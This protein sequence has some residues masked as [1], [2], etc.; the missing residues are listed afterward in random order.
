MRNFVKA[1]GASILNKPS[2]R[3]PFARSCLSPSRAEPPSRLFA[4]C[5]ACLKNSASE[6]V[7]TGLSTSFFNP[8]SH[9]ASFPGGEFFSAP[10]LASGRRLPLSVSSPLSSEKQSERGRRKA[11]R[12]CAACASSGREAA[13][14]G[15]SRSALETKG[16][17]STLRQTSTGHC[18]FFA[19]TSA[20]TSKDTDK[21]EPRA[22][23]TPKLVLQRDPRRARRFPQ[24]L[25]EGQYA[26]LPA[27]PIPDS[28][29][30]PPY[31]RRFNA[32]AASHLDA[33]DEPGEIQTP[34][35]LAK[36]RAAATVAA[37]ALKLGLEAAKEGVTTEDLDKIVHEYIVS[38]GAY[39]AAVNFH[40]FPKAVCA[41]VNEA[42]CHGI[43]DLRPL[44]D[45]DIVTLDC[46]AYVDGFFGDCA[47]TAMVGN[48]SPVHRD[49]VETTK[50]CLNEA[51]EFIKPGV[52][53]KE[54]GRIV[55]QH[56]KQKGFSVVL[57]FCGHF[58]GRK[59]HLPPLIS[60]VYPND[61][62]GI[63]RVGQTFTIEPILC[64][65]SPA[66]YTW[67]D[68][69][70]IVTQDCSRAAQFEH[71]I[72]MTPEGAEILTKPTI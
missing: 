55:S 30:R 38:V 16:A 61:T 67:K 33:A 60:H 24:T 22:I 58:I 68:G 32:S 37:N 72:L 45:G 14:S 10:S 54:V 49:L 17:G 56:A 57:E 43:P 36:I 27:Q 26:V 40:N 13:V 39:P 71:T 62:E 70:T 8:P 47:G 21:S 65:G 29:P 3:S 46:T 23:L 63:F 69:W 9:R 2:A 41:S 12:R 20:T 66:L 15:F 19:T 5:P 44:Q 31:A 48:V 53:I 51:I 18:R 34:E 4:T 50:E 64:E 52:P 28:I 6:S 11:S 35:A 1:T 7:A 25:V 42:V 59:M